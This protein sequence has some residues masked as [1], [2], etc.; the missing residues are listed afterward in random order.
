[1]KCT[2]NLSFILLFKHGVLLGHG[3]ALLYEPDSYRFKLQCAIRH[4]FPSV[5][6]VACVVITSRAM[7]S[8]SY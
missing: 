2:V 6:M 7:S 4:I 1:M 3:A 8:L 5:V